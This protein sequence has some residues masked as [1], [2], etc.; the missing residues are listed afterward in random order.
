MISR[1]RRLTPDQPFGVATPEDLIVL[2]LIAN[3]SRDIAD[4]TELTQLPDLDW[5]FID[6]WC[7]VWHADRA[8]GLREAMER[9]RKHIEDL[10]RGD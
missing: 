8:Q 1:A 3:R 2:K 5:P 6:R 10:Y 9:E 7:D 4:C